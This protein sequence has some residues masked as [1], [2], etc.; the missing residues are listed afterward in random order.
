MAENSIDSLENLN[1]FLGEVSA[2][3]DLNHQ[4]TSSQAR[5]VSSTLAPCKD[6]VVETR[7]QLGSILLLLNEALMVKSLLYF[8]FQLIHLSS[9]RNPAVTPHFVPFQLLRNPFWQ[10]L[11]H[12]HPLTSLVWP[13][14]ALTAWKLATQGETALRG[15][16]LL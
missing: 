7:A 14:S 4:D 10:R 1:E 13:L 6:S 5:A 3:M 9:F 11:F 8:H 12:H 16:L 2:K 15:S